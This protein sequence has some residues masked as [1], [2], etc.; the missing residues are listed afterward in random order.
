MKFKKDILYLFL[1]LI[2]FSKNLLAQNTTVPYRV[3]AELK[4]GLHREKNLLT[5]PGGRLSQ[6]SHTS[7]TT[8]INAGVYLNDG[9]SALTLELDIVT[10]GNSFI[11]D[12]VPSSY[13]AGVGFNR[14]TTAY[15]YSLPLIYNKISLF[16]KI[17]PSITFNSRPKG[18]TG[19]T[20]TV[21]YDN[22][23]DTTAFN[24]SHDT[25]NRNV[26][27][28]LTVGAGILFTPNPR[29]RFSYSV[30]PSWNFT[31]NDV[32]IQDIRYRFFNDPATY[33]ARALSTGTT[34]TQSIALGYAFGN[35]QQRKEEINKKK[36]LYTAEE[37]EK[38]KRWSLL[39]HTS[40]TYPNIKFN[41]PAGH[42]T[43][44]PVER[45]TFGAQLFYRFAPKWQ[46]ATG[47]ESVPF[48][49]EARLPTMVGGSGAYMPNS[50]QVPL[51]AEYQLL[52]SRGRIKFE[53]LVRGGFAL[54]MQ[55]KFIEDPD[56]SFGS[57]T[58]L[59]PVYYSEEEKKDRP[60]ENFFAL[61]T[62]TRVNI[63][64]SKRIFLTGYVQYQMALGNNV[65]HRST[66]RY[67]LN[68]PSAPWNRAQL[69]T[70][71]TNFLPGFGIGFKL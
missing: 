31:S 11:F 21:F 13:G 15:N 35:T 32:M 66:V 5:D 69:T 54:G 6:R 42:L 23:D 63:Y 19:L 27:A 53:W 64:L 33:Q 43:D 38:R 60:S 1:I 20:A 49:L 65:F 70:N 29:L 16:G 9:R 36:Q 71:G 24:I 34:F 18:S 51:F 68:D 61:L 3:F 46:L 67:Q 39:F 10:I 45:F 56:V 7:P 30:Y 44:K 28:G 50:I 58:E 41:D 26:F 22:N 17:G 62:G 59:Q 48:Q 8:G 37:W 57:H 52:Q 40:H 2:S 14:I 55:R 25:Q 47:F 4:A 12:S